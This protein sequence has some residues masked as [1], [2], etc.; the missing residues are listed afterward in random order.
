MRDK[1]EKQKV[2]RFSL[3]L[4]ILVPV[5][6]V[7]ISGCFVVGYSSVKGYNDKYRDLAIENAKSI[8]AIASDLID[9]E[10]LNYE[11]L[12][13]EENAISINTTLQ[14]LLEQ[15]HLKQFYTLHKT[16]NGSIVYGLNSD[17]DSSKQVGTAATNLVD[18]DLINK[19]FSGTVA[20]SPVIKNLGDDVHLL[21][22]YQPIIDADENVT[23]VLCIDYDASNILTIRYQMISRLVLVLVVTL[24]FDSLII[25][26]IVKGII[27]NIRQVNEKICELANNN[28]DLTQSLDIHSGDELEL[29]AGNVNTL[30][31]Y[32]RAIMVSIRDDSLKLSDSVVAITE[33][34]TDSES[35]I[36]DVSSTMEQMSAAMEETSAS[37][38][39][40]SSLIK[41]VS[42]TTG[43]VAKYA[44]QSEM[45]ARATVKKASNIESQVDEN[46]TKAKELSDQLTIDV[47]ES[48]ERSNAVTQIS[49][50]TENIL[51]IASQTNLL[52]LNAS[53][54]AARAG[55]S[56]R[57]F[58]VVATEIGKLANTSADAANEIKKVSDE[59]IAA[60]ELLAEQTE[61]MLTFLDEVAM[62]GYDELKDTGIAY[63]TDVETMGRQMEAFCN[64]TDYIE[65]A[66]HKILENMNAIN[67]AIEESTTGVNSIANTT[68]AINA[69]VSEIQKTALD[70][71]AIADELTNEVRKFKLD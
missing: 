27:K 59:V 56:G 21:S 39:E 13:S 51:E 9:A 65:Q 15:G 67:I 7:V 40:I 14:M 33:K 69:D 70:N 16:N 19:A 8:A 20:N 30:L 47:K 23:A 12:L 34:V 3:Q 22:V 26:L 42:D 54:E 2:R 55:Q 66:I 45:D 11:N 24:L 4:K 57:G 28:G 64:S 58:A 63:K 46:I 61:R 38:V 62:K 32:I 44:K 35:E 43:D 18:S 37:I 1:K 31:S 52:A 68:T 48:L 10:A 6:L 5:I 41:Q 71:K 25:C 50:L 49:K 29:I 60:V 53:I 36:A 17:I